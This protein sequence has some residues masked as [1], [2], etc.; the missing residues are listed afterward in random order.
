MAI[1]S[2]D[3]ITFGKY[4]GKIWGD[5]ARIDPKYIIWVDNNIDVEFT[6]LFLDSVME[7]IGIFPENNTT[8]PDYTNSMYY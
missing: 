4:K 3:K 7:N 5:I 1:K 6:P 8:Y 2:S